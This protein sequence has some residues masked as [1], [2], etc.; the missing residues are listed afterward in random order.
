MKFGNVSKEEAERS[1][2]YQFIIGSYGL[3]E[4]FIIPKDSVIVVHIM[5]KTE[6]KST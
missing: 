4:Q 6:L 5:H 2:S 3:N 1:N